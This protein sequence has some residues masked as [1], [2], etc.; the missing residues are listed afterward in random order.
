LFEDIRTKLI[1]ATA[2]RDKCQADIQERQCSIKKLKRELKNTEEAQLI[3]QTVAM[4]TQQELEYKISEIVSLALSAVFD[5]P[6]EFKVE[7]NIKRNKTEAEIHFYKNG[8]AFDPMTETG[9]G[10]VDIASFALRIALWNLS[11]PKTRNT[12]ILDEPFRFLSKNL[13]TKASEMLSVISKKLNIQFIIVTHIAELRE[14]ADKVFMVEH[15]GNISTV[16]A[17]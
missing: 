6:Y 10:V 11:S 3:L 16:K 14:A 8:I 7:F 9:G 13:Q 15:D 5:D 4:Q 1:T 2:H 17:M 12:I